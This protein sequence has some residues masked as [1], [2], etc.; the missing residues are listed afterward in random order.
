[1]EHAVSE[2]FE[3]KL[4]DK[5][6]ASEACPHGNRATGDRPAD[7]R[8]RGLRPLSEMKNET[9]GQVVSIFERDRKLLEYLNGM[10]IEP[11][12][13]VNVVTANYD[14][15]I[16]LKVKDAYVQL[17]KPAAEKIWIDPSRAAGGKTI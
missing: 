10:G 7:R 11:G 8:K 15:T 16:T 9:A 14:A 2:D 12:I 17:G 5:L 3:R 6:G 1:M 4:I 13:F